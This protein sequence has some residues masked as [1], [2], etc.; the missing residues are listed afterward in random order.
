MDRKTDLKKV[1]LW[2]RVGC[3]VVFVI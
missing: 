1:L 3:F 2:L